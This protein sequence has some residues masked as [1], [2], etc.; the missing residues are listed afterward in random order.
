MSGGVERG[1]VMLEQLADQ[2]FEADQLYYTAWLQH[3][4]K[5]SKASRRALKRADEVL[6]RLKKRADEILC[7]VTK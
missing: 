7:G 4:R 1:T 2:F 3:Q 5:P 6:E